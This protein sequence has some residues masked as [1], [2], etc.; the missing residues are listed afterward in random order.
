MRIRLKKGVALAGAIA[1]AAVATTL[2]IYN[3][4]QGNSLNTSDIE[5]SGILDELEEALGVEDTAQ[6]TPPLIA[7]AD[8]SDAAAAAGLLG[9][10]FEEGSDAAAVQSESEAS[11]Q[12]S[13]AE[14]VPG[15]DSGE[16]NAGAVGGQNGQDNVYPATETAG[17]G[18]VAF[19]EPRTEEYDTYVEAVPQTR[20]ETVVNEQR[21]V[22]ETPVTVT[23]EIT[24]QVEAEPGD[25]RAQSF[26]AS[27]DEMTDER[28]Q[29]EAQA[30]YVA[31][32]E[33]LRAAAEAAGQREYEERTGDDLPENNNSGDAFVI[34]Y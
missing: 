11:V 22:V 28:R 26:A 16:E 8:G 34:F 9:N 31:D 27:A 21:V 2:I 4:N 17:N 29:Q 23:E 12:E 1:G 25:F 20:T 5:N 10:S 14:A 7:D 30:A 3:V 6:T 13:T 19:E 24:E 18:V 15:S 32:Q 33:R